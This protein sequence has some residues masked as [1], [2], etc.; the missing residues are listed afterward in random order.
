MTSD[1]L[2]NPPRSY[3]LINVLRSQCVLNNTMYYLV[4]LINIPANVPV[5]FSTFIDILHL[6]LS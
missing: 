2:R 3:H 5:L 6:L 1:S 4:F